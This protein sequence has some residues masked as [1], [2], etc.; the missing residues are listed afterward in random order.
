MLKNLQ[1]KKDDWMW[2]TSWKKSLSLFQG[3]TRSRYGVSESWIVTSRVNTRSSKWMTIWKFHILKQ[4]FLL[5]M[6]CFSVSL[7]EPRGNSWIMAETAAVALFYRFITIKFH[8]SFIAACLTNMSN[9][10]LIL[11][12]FNISWI[13]THV[14][15]GGGNIFLLPIYVFMTLM[16]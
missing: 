14:G 1:I 7:C 6:F 4:N 5:H 16:V 3:L 13:H 2:C 11:I 15:S 12:C 9:G 8:V 10:S